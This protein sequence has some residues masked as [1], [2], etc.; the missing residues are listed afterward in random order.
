[1]PPAATIRGGTRRHSHPPA[2]APTGT[3]ISSRSST[4]AAPNWS[5]GVVV[6]RANNGTATSA[7][8][9]GTPTSR[10]TS[11]APQAPAGRSCRS[12]RTGAGVRRSCTTN[13]IAA[14]AGIGR[15]TG[16]GAGAWGAGWAEG[17]H[18]GGRVGGGEG[19]DQAA[20]RDDDQ[21]RA[22]HVDLGGQRAQPAQRQDGAL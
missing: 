6:A 19:P 17:D 7:A 4:R 20:E 1:M 12:G 2:T 22:E 5:P 11:S 15:R 14:T 8:T 16:P 10:L 18:R 3:A 9:S 13:A 21:Q